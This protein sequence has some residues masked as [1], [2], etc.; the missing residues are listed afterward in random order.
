MERSDETRRVPSGQRP[1]AIAEL[2]LDDGEDLIHKSTGGWLRAAGG[3]DR[4]RLLGFLDAHA[5]QMPRTMLRYAM[6]HLEPEQ[7]EHYRGLSANR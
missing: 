3:V 1:F 5:A 7:R 2:L 6:E 4:D